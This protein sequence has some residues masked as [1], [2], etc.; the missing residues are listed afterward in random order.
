MIQ[1]ILALAIVAAAA[2]WLLARWL[3]RRGTSRCCGE[4]ECP[5]AK[6]TAR[7][8]SDLAKRRGGAWRSS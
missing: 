3:R 7:R 6:A 4:P 2:G 1:R 5:A 8:I